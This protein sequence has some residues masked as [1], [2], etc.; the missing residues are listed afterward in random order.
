M[1]LTGVKKFLKT[2][3]YDKNKQW[4]SINPKSH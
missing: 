4:N 1:K 3:L 2:W